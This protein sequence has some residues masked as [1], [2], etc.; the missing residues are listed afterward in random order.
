MFCYC[1][2]SNAQKWRARRLVRHLVGD[3]AHGFP[4]QPVSLHAGEVEQPLLCGLHVLGA[5]RITYGSREVE[6][7][8]YARYIRDS[9]IGCCITVRT[10]NFIMTKDR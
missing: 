10:M 1:L 6:V 4:L 7:H 2:V 8:Q 3:I 9:F 5:A